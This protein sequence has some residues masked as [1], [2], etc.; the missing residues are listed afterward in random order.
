MD[1]KLDEMGLAGVDFFRARLFDLGVRGDFLLAPAVVAVVAVVA[2][3]EDGDE[4]G[5][6][7][8]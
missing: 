8:E 2:C 3:F 4:G 5:Y 1:A 7:N 6:A